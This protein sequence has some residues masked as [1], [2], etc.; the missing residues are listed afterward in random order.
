[1][2]CVFVRDVGKL[3]YRVPIAELPWST[4]FLFRV[5]ISREIRPAAAGFNPDGRGLS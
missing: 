2:L 3:W 4:S 5:Y 1:M